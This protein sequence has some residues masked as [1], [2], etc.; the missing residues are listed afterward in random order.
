MAGRSTAITQ[1]IH[2]DWV[3][4][5]YIEVNILFYMILYNKLVSNCSV[6]PES[7]SLMTIR[8]CSLFISSNGGK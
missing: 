4:R 7:K 5:E 6:Y 8:H 2:Q 3:N 1:Q